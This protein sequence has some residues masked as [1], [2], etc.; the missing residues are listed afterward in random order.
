[1]GPFNRIFSLSVSGDPKAGIFLLLEKRNCCEIDG[2]Y[3][4]QILII[5]RFFP[6]Q[7]L[8]FYYHAQHPGDLFLFDSCYS[9]FLFMKKQ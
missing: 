7:F 8:Q 5:A 2:Q 9:E 3:H 6:A 4:P 1:M